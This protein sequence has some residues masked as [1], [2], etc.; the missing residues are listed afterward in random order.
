MRLTG[1]GVVL[2]LGLILVPFADRF[3]CHSYRR[4]HVDSEK[5]SPDLPKG[6][7]ES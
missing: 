7:C 2:A 6:G 4:R 1:L 5:W 3:G